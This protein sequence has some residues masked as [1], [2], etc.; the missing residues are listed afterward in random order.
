MVVAP[1]LPYK[2]RFNAQ[3]NWSRK[4][5]LIYFYF[6]ALDRGFARDI[7]DL[8]LFAAIFILNLH[9]ERSTN[10]SSAVPDSFVGRG[11]EGRGAEE[12]RGAMRAPPSDHFCSSCNALAR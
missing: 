2:S 11:R 10:T 7:D 9:L 3:K 4:S 12:R 1:T 5:H 6:T 8:L